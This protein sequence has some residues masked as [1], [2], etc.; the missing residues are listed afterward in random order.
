MTLHDVVTT[1]LLVVIPVFLV[2]PPKRAA[3]LV[4]VRVP[5]TSR[6]RTV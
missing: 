5:A 3:Q 2:M 6:R 4:P 1:L